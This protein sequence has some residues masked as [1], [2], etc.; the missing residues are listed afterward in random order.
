[1]TK[2]MLT[3]I[4]YNLFQDT[5]FEG[6]LISKYVKKLSFIIDPPIQNKFIY[7]KAI[8]NKIAS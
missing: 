3:W 2:Y 1:M 6:Y 5:A 8:I 4:L 7:F